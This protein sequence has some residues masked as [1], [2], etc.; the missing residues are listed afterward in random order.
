[1]AGIL[2]SGGF[3]LG[4]LSDPGGVTLEY[5]RALARG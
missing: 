4:A 3:E 2:K 1:M 5:R